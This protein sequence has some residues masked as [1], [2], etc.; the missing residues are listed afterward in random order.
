MNKALFLDR[1]G[2]INIDY[3]HVFEIEKFHFIDGIFDLCKVAQNK[4]Y[5]IFVITNQA[6]IAKGYYTE[7]QFHIL[8]K[9]MISEFQRRNIKINKVY[10]C[11]YHEAGVIKKYKKHS[12]HRKPNPGMIL[13]AEKDF[14]ID[15]KQSILI[16]DKQSDMQAAHN[17][18]VGVKILYN[19]LAQDTSDMIIKDFSK[20]TLD[21]IFGIAN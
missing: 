11:P 9:Y 17:A 18:G 12:Y 20:D 6:G 1:D 8:N 5:M 14:E 4:G 7:E 21:L 10:Y 3:G 19:S 16:G 15:L 13:E 2:V